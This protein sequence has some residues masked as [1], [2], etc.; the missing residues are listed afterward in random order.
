MTNES[1]RREIV[2]RKPYA[3]PKLTHYG[4]LKELTTGGTGNASEG[5]MGQRPRP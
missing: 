3:P 2:L 1:N 5:S 4:D